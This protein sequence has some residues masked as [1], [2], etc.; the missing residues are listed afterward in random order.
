MA[1]EEKSE[2]RVWASL[3]TTI[4]TRPYENV[5]IDI[6]ISGIPLDCSDGHLEE[7]LKGA[8]ISL[9]RIVDSLATEMARR[10]ENDFPNRQAN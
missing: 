5:K 7:I 9:Q 3:G 2:P 1:G 6:G 10:I 4:Q 8:N